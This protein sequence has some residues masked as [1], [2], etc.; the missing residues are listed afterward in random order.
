[1]KKQI[2]I[3][4]VLCAITLASFGQN[5][6]EFPVP[7]SDPA[8][9]GKLKVDI[10]YGGITVKG[11]PRKDVLVKYSS[12]ESRK[13]KTENPDGLKRISGSTIN[14]DV[15]EKA[16]VVLV[17]S[18]SWNTKTNLEIEV[19]IGFD[20]KVS[21]YNDGDIWISNIQGEIEIGT[22]NGGIKAENISGSVVASTYNGDI[23]VTFDKVSSVPMS[24]STYNG[25]V[26]LT[27]PALLKA[28]LKMKTQQGEILSGFDM[29]VL[30]S[31]PIQKKEANGSFKVIVDEWVKADIGGGGPEISMR[32]YNGDIKIRKKG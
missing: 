31:E 15:S 23:I 17:E 1:M 6:G 7:L 11:T 9:R 16:N 20:I 12:D 4:I 30:K 5:S 13:K 2:L 22:Y 10:H 28:T 26:D 27:F 3:T 32:N 24:Y 18:S 25:D 21:S 19:P 14:L 8:K 29:N